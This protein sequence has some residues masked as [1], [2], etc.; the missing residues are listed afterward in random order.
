MLD[1]GTLSVL[2]GTHH[3]RRR[4]VAPFREPVK[5]RRHVRHR[6]RQES[7]AIDELVVERG[8]NGVARPSA[9]GAHHEGASTGAR[10]LVVA[11][12]P[13]VRMSNESTPS[14]EVSP[15]GGRTK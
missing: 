15:V 9:P 4:G 2:V 14:G 11:G 8:A 10:G 13:G 12:L 3:E 5:A 7:T 6:E 1:R